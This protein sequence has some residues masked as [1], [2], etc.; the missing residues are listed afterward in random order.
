MNLS[1]MTLLGLIV[2]TGLMSANEKKT[3]TRQLDSFENVVL[4]G[5]GEVEIIFG[6]E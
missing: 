1:K 2:G 3:E 6:N 5:H 4:E